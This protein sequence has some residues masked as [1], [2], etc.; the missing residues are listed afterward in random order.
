VCF[1]LQLQI[2]SR[3][4]QR[5]SSVRWFFDLVLDRTNSWNKLARAELLEQSSQGRKA[6]TNC[7]VQ[8]S[9]K[10]LATA[11][12]LEQNGQ[13]NSSKKLAREE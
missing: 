4:L 10:K 12:Q 2:G 3:T 13:G 11:E 9:L 1:G 7:S 6:G 5:A 8:N